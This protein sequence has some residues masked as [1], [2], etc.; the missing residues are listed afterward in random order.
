MGRDDWYRNTTWNS[1]VEAEFFAKLSRARN[2]AQYLRIQA[3]Y[4]TDAGYP[5]QALGLYEKFFAIGDEWQYA[6]A[7]ADKAE[8]HLLLGDV[9]AAI[10]SY[11]Q[12]LEVETARPNIGTRA[13]L[14][15]PYLIASKRLR[16]LYARALEVLATSRL[17]AFP[18]DRYV[19]N[20][21]RALILQEQGRSSVARSFAQAALAASAETKSGFRYHQDLGLVASTD[22]EFGTRLKAIATSST[23]ARSNSPHGKLLARALHAVFTAV[24]FVIG[25]S[26]R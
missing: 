11:E 23:D 12:A 16:H 26:R 4:L 10:V 25:P 17:N 19:A 14:D 20:G 2:R 3:G 9:N 8:A 18:V 1:R 13:S 5:E 22:D 7:Y 24:G 15:L 6:L 21:V